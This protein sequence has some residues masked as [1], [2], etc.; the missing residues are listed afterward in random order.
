MLL[1]SG[2]QKSQN[3]DFARD[4]SQNRRDCWSRTEDRG[5]GNCSCPSISQDIQYPNS[6]LTLIALSLVA[7][8]RRE[9]TG[10]VSITRTSKQS[11]SRQYV[12]LTSVLC[13][14]KF[15]PPWI[16]TAP[17]QLSYTSS[18]QFSPLIDIQS[19]LCPICYPMSTFSHLLLILILRSFYDLALVSLFIH[20]PPTLALGLL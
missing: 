19:P 7:I 11:I 1:W 8:N 16:F 15:F 17:P 3:L 6:L 20:S 13:L 4:V 5:K 2:R 14:F 10:G 12:I 18:F 9:R